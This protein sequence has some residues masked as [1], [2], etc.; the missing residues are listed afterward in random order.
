MDFPILEK[1][2]GIDFND[3]S[4]LKAAFTHKT[5]AKENNTSSYERLEFLGDSVLNFIVGDFLF[6]RGVYDEGVLTKYRAAYVREKS[7][8]RA[9]R[10]LDLADFLLMGEE[11]RRDEKYNVQIDDLYESLVAAIYLDKGF[12]KAK[13]F[14]ETTL[15][16]YDVT[17]DDDYKSRVQEIMQKRYRDNVLTYKTRE[18]NP[19]ALGDED[20][21]E[22]E[23]W[24]NNEKLAAGRGRNKKSAENSAAMS[25]IGKIDHGEV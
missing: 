3:K 16:H 17:I 22:A 21:F 8:K 15:L 5:Y 14:V 10:D 20:R 12:E 23:V 11:L 4:L 2:I 1:K 7:L 6:H 13:T 19:S 9:A 24:I 18:I 25:L